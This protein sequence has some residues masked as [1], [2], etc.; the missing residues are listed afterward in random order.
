MNIIGLFH[1]FFDYFLFGKVHIFLQSIPIDV[2]N[3]EDDKGEQITSGSVQDS[4]PSSSVERVRSKL[5]TKINQVLTFICCTSFLIIIFYAIFRQDE[6]VP[7]TIQTAFWTTLGWFGGA[8]GTFFQFD[9][10]QH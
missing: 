10:S 7:E 9:S 6:P 5:I 8:L 4:T 3:I 2:V 1:R